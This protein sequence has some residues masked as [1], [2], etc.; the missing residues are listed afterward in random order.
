MSDPFDHVSSDIVGAP[1]NI[2]ATPMLQ[3]WVAKSHNLWQSVNVIAAN[4]MDDEVAFLT[5]DVIG[6]D[7]NVHNLHMS[8][9]VISVLPYWVI[10]DRCYVKLMKV[11]R[12]AIGE[13]ILE[14]PSAMNST[15]HDPFIRI[16]NKIHANWST[17]EHAVI[18]HVEDL[19]TSP[20]RTQEKISMFL[21]NVEM[22]VADNDVYDISTVNSSDMKTMFMISVLKNWNERRGNSTRYERSLPSQEVP[23]VRAEPTIT[24]HGVV[25]NTP[26]IAQPTPRGTP[27]GSRTMYVDF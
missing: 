7:G 26:T 25:L 20:G 24:A 22:S 21:I 17:D 15:I 11:V 4:F 19:Y 23:V 3:E 9:D 27:R 6:N 18:V 14:I 2:L 5:L 8:R 12:M 16:Q 13:E 10:G 1:T